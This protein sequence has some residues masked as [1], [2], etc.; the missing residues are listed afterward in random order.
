MVRAQCEILTGLLPRQ[1]IVVKQ[2]MEGGRG[3]GERRREGEG[4]E[5][6][7]EG[8]AEEE[9]HRVKEEERGSEG[10]REKEMI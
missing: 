1:R 6:V 2:V 5:R 8:E 3:G 4:G 10:E 7:I 9:R